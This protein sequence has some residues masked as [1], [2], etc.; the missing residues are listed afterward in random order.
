MLK[1]T[2]TQ[3]KRYATDKMAKFSLQIKASEIYQHIILLF[4]YY[5]KIFTNKQLMGNATFIRLSKGRLQRS[6]SNISSTNENIS[7]ETVELNCNN[8][9]V[10]IIATAAPVSEH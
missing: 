4:N 5:Y 8:R 6:C 1:N 3:S 7:C 10:R 2:T 9:D